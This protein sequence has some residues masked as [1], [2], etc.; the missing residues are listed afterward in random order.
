MS[1]PHVTKLPPMRPSPTST[2]SDKAA[3]HRSAKRTRQ[4][5]MPTATL[6]MLDAANSRTAGLVSAV[7]CASS[8]EMHW[9]I[10]PPG[11]LLMLTAIL[12]SKSTTCSRTSGA[13]LRKPCR[14][15]AETQTAE[16]SSRSPAA[17]ITVPPSSL[18][19]LIWSVTDSLRHLRSCAI[20][21]HFWAPATGLVSPN[22]TD[23]ESTQRFANSSCFPLKCMARLV[24]AMAAFT[25]TKMS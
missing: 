16:M 17:R 9:S 2:F 23:T 21:E 24:S 7:I 3:T 6:P 12:A 1:K 18:A 13:R 14:A 22:A 25:R 5:V 10:T 19:V 4:P 15:S 8:E 20:G 11:P